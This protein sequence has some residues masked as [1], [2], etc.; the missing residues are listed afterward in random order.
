MHFCIQSL[1]LSESPVYMSTNPNPLDAIFSY[2]PWGG[3]FDFQNGR[4]FI[5]LITLS[6][7]LLLT[8]LFGQKQQTEE[9]FDCEILP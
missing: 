6:Y 5:Y 9:S 3:H 4:Y 2:R 1:K 8:R 7:F